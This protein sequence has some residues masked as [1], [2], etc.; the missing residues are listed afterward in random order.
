MG[1]VWLIG[2]IA[3]LVGEIFTPGFV[4]ACFGVAGMLTSVL[5]FV[6]FGWRGQLIGFILATILVLVT[7]RPLLLKA[8][9]KTRTNTDALIDQVGIVKERIDGVPASGRVLVGGENWRAVSEDGEDV[10]VDQQVTVVRVEGTKLIV[11]RL[12]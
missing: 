3:L 10:D 9:G 11:K 1:Y 2:G 6:G 7:L 12:A 8:S 5:A 4:L